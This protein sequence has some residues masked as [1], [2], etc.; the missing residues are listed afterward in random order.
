MTDGEC[1]ELSIHQRY[2]TSFLIRGKENTVFSLRV[3]GEWHFRA[4]SVETLNVKFCLEE[5]VSIA[6][7]ARSVI[8]DCNRDELFGSA[9]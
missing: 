4:V 2:R 7:F 8:F 5:P 1:R 9:W 3:R 6:A